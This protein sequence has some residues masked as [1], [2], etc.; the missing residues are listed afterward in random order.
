M[1]FIKKLVRAHVKKSDSEDRKLL[2]WSIVLDVFV[3][4]AETVTLTNENDCFLEMVLVEV[5]DRLKNS[6]RKK[7]RLVLYHQIEEHLFQGNIRSFEDSII[8]GSDLTVEDSISG[9]MIPSADDLIWSDQISEQLQGYIDQI[10]EKEALILRLHFF[11]DS[12]LADIAKE[13]KV[14]TEQVREKIK[15]SMRRLKDIVPR[16]LFQLCNE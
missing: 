6:E 12:E 8:P 2:V 16:K 14:T 3:A 5:T 1:W 13:L 15:L 4:C 9:T 11:E 7:K 10:P